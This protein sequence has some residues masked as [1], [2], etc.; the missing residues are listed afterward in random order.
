MSDTAQATES[1]R[2]ARAERLFIGPDGNKVE[3]KMD[4]TG[5]QY[6]S[7]QVDRSVSFQFF[8]GLTAK[9]VAEATGVDENRVKLVFASAAMGWLTKIGNVVNTVVNGIPAGTPDEALDT[10]EGWHAEAMTGIWREKAEGVGVARIDK[11]ALARAVWEYLQEAGRASE[12]S[13]DKVRERLESEPVYVRKVRQHGEVGKRY[14]A[15]VGMPRVTD[16]DLI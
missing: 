2:T 6:K 5:A 10:A 11:D 14:D 12:T 4:A 15:L 7:K 8:D 1:S 3:D 13:F 16:D 9:E